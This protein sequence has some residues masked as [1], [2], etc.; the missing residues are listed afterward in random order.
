MSANNLIAILC[1]IAVILAYFIYNESGLA[2]MLGFLFLTGISMVVISGIDAL[3][4]KCE[5][6]DVI[7]KAPNKT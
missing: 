7:A 1:N 6:L 4:D 3:L 2:T 5:K